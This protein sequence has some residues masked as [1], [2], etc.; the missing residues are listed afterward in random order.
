MCTKFAS[1][2]GSLLVGYAALSIIFK[3]IDMS[4][5]ALPP[6][7]RHNSQGYATTRIAKTEDRT[8]TFISIRQLGTCWKVHRLLLLLKKA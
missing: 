1:R 2:E 5:Y 3:S 4:S 6:A 8:A 7:H